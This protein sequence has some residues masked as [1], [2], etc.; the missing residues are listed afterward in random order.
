MRGRLLNSV[1]R[2]WG[3]DTAHKCRSIRPFMISAGI[4][5]LSVAA[6]LTIGIGESYGRGGTAKPPP[7]PA[8]GGIVPTVTILPPAGPTLLNIAPTVNGFSISGHIQAVTSLSAC[9]APTNLGGTVTV[10]GIVITIPT[11]TIIQYPANTLTWT[12]AVCG[13]APIATNGSGSTA[14]AP[15]IYP[16]VEIRVDGNIVN[17]PGA[18]GSTGIAGPGAAST[19]VGALVYISQHAVNSGSGY[20]S[21]IDYTDGSIYVSTAGGTVATRLLI[22]DPKGR[23]GRQQSSPDARFQVDDA[24]P[25]IKAAASGYPM[26]V[27]RTAVAAG[28]TLC[29]QVNRPTGLG[30][31]CRTFANAGIA[32]RIAGA[33]IRPAPLNGFCAGFVMKAIANMP[34][35]AALVRP[36]ARGGNNDPIATPGTDPDPRQMAPF[37]VGDYITWAGTLVVGGA[38]TAPVPGAGAPATSTRDIIWVHTIDANVGIYTQPATLPAYI[39]VGGFGIGVD[40]QPTG[41]AVVGVESTARLVLEANTSDVGSLVDIYLD[42]KGFSLPAGSLTGPLVADSSLPFGPVRPNEYFR[43]LTLESMTGALAEQNDGRTLTL[44]SS[45]AQPFGGGIETQFVGPQ[46]GRA[47]IRAIK[48][49]SINGTAAACPLAG[50]SQNC[51]VTNSPTRYMRV[52]LRSLCAPAASDNPLGTRSIGLNGV[53]VPTSNMDEGAANAPGR[54][55]DMNG[56]RGNLPGAST[57]N[58]NGSAS[59]PAVGG[60]VPGLVNKTPGNVCWQSAQYANGLFTGQYMAPVGEFIFPENTLSGFPIVANTFYQMGFMVWGEGGDGAVAPQNPLPW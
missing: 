58:Y 60:V 39:A 47:R 28:D 38:A 17:T 23:Y 45:T 42:D 4:L 52:V 30:N 16:G 51:G 35:T 6:G 29:P 5:A 8:P 10:N 55:F 44:A 31:T 56:T 1:Q 43:W 24:N 14:P 32:F 13:I 48:I 40:P 53:A 46:P 21:F 41:A 54:W 57:G 7:A 34:G 11:D 33:D 59:G 37:E 12:D 20:I 36:A 9:G 18:A 22:N 15:A 49:P 26:C 3:S 27:P 19:H 2:V 25:T 50:G